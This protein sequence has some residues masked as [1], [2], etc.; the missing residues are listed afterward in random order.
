MKLLEA[1][2]AR[3]E[4]LFQTTKCHLKLRNILMKR[5]SVEDHLGINYCNS[6]IMGAGRRH[7][8]QL[9]PVIRRYLM[10]RLAG[11]DTLPLNIITK[12]LCKASY[13][14]A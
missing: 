9:D 1:L 6:F 11:S 5:K 10:T 8:G 4:T 3:I 12:R 13:L 14:L 2:A 7:Q